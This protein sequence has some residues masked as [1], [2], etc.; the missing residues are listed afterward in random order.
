MEYNS[1]ITD[2]SLQYFP[3]RRQAGMLFLV[4]LADPPLNLLRGGDFISGFNNLFKKV[5]QQ[6]KE[7]VPSTGGESGVGLCYVKKII[8]KLLL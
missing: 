7:V 2:E 4:I 3:F 1:G 8:I 5:T 6:S